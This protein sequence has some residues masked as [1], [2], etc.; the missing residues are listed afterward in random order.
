MT[1]QALSTSD[2]WPG[3]ARIAV[4]LAIAFE[5]GSEL[6]PKEGDRYAEPT[7]EFGVT[8]KKGVRNVANESAFQYGLK[9]GAPRFLKMLEEFELKAT[10]LAAA[11]ALE[12]SPELTRRIMQGG[13]EFCG[14]GYRWIHQFNMDEE[15]E[16]EF[17]RKTVDSFAKIT[18]ARPVGWLSRY[19]V[20]PHTR[21]LLVEQGFQY[22]M[23]DYSD[24]LPWWDAVQGKPI[25]VS[26]SALDTN[27]FKFWLNP[28]YGPEDWLRYMTDSFDQLY[29][30][31]ATEP[32]ML[33]MNLHLRMFGR[34]GRFR[35]LV[36]FIRYL[37]KHSGVWIATRREIAEWW[38]QQHPYSPHNSDASP[39]SP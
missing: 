38:A 16:R 29:E 9:A 37:K 1:Q 27:D 30:E 4:S 33:S 18:G 24:D 19:M 5:E 23:D 28:G 8:M 25:L 15:T 26:P 22:H 17:I 6:S 32:K 10:F 14:H 12:R 31:G 35:N 20:S 11:Q 13:H 2:T 7:D 39:A 21:R 3:N 36:R 34:P